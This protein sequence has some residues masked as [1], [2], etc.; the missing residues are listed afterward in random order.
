MLRDTVAR[1]A[2][3]ADTPDLWAHV[4]E[5]G[6]LGVATDEA[7]GG[8]GLGL[9]GAAALQEEFGRHLLN[10]PYLSSVVA[11]AGVLARCTDGPEHLE[12]LIAG[13]TRIAT[14]FA[15]LF[16]QRN[17]LRI[18]GDKLSGRVGPI[19]ALD[20]ADLV[21]ITTPEPLLLPLDTPGLHCETA[22][23]IDG[24]STGMLTLDKVTLPAGARLAPDG[25]LYG[26]GD[27]VLVA[28]ASDNLGLARALYDLTLEHV[29]TRQQFGRPIG[30]FQTI[31]F[32]MV[33]LW[34]ALEETRSLTAAAIAATDA[35]EADASDLASAAWIRSL[36]S[37]HRIV[38]EAIQ[39]HG[40]I[41]MTDEWHGAGFVKR[42]LVNE[43]LIGPPQLHLPRLHPTAPR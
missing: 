35:G 18:E 37:G 2:A 1:V 28:A 9:A 19:E 36:Q 13:E 7:Q 22:P 10:L 39:L 29:R 32:R 8:I 33:D 6:W 16:G 23:A 25:P 15:D 26:I 17:D 42:F 4:A 27:A 40:A 12:A 14:G 24:R 41:G 43:L 34:I 5:L 20:R 21:L 31:Q 30:A 38:E 3:R 11:A